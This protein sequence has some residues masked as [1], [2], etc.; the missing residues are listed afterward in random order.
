VGA[1]TAA[2]YRQEIYDDFIR[3]KELGRLRMEP[4]DDPLIYGIRMAM[5]IKVLKLRIRELEEEL[6]GKP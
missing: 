6:Y 5:E 2:K 1:I 4:V 3:R